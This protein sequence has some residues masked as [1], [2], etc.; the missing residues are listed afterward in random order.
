MKKEEETK[1]GPTL[2]DDE[3]KKINKI[4]ENEA[5]FLYDRKLE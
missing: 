2:N 4:L 3:G 5:S 1:G